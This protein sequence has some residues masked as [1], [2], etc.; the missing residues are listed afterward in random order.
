MG[1]ASGTFAYRVV[2]Q[3]YCGG[4]EHSRHRTLAGAR[5]AIRRH[6]RTIARLNRHGGGHYH[7]CRIQRLVNG[8]WR[9]C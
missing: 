6:D 5:K 1:V 8:E 3:V 7:D 4:G 2:S 9:P